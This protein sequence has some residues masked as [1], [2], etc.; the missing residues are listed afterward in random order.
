MLA[1]TDLDGHPRIFNNSVD[2]GADE[3]AIIC[4]SISVGQTTTS[5][6][7]TVVNAKVR[8]ESS[9]NLMTTNWAITGNVITSDQQIIVLSDPSSANIKK[10][11]RLKLAK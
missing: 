11:Y 2:M 1:S 3:A 8:L 7:D 6:W 5:T 4:R 9:T 10:F